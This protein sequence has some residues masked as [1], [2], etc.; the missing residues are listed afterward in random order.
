MLNFPPKYSQIVSDEEFLGL[1]RCAIWKR[2]SKKMF[3]GVVTRSIGATLHLL[4]SAHTCSGIYLPDYR[5]T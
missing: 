5:R 2:F 3:L 1:L 4:Y